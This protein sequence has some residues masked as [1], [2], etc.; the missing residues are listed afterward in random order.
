M[1]EKKTTNDVETRN[2]SPF[3]LSKTISYNIALLKCHLPKMF[4]P[5]FQLHF[6]NFQPYSFSLNILAW[7][8][9]LFN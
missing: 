4:F 8:D 1:S 2:A 5:I 6:D 3:L 7:S 9:V